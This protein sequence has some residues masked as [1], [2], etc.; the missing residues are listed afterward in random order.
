ME[1]GGDDTF[2]TSEP[3][4]ASG[5]ITRPLH[6]TML[7]DSGADNHFIDSNITPQI[8]KFV[9]RF[10]TF[11]KSFIIA[12]GGNAKVQATG[13]GVIQGIIKHAS[14]ERTRHSLPVIIAPG[15]G[16]H[17]FFVTKIAE[18][19]TVSFHIGKDESYFE[20]YGVKFLV[21][22]KRGKKNKLYFDVI[23]DRKPSN[24]FISKVQSSQSK[25]RVE[26]P[27]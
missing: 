2:Y 14:G 3:Y 10:K 22:P 27:W 23:L 1:D 5:A 16:Q 6:M 20:K 11:S 15:L 7:L 19:G 17:L 9:A 26:K 18:N 24:E 25:E 13:C 8:H 4:T 12:C 21:R